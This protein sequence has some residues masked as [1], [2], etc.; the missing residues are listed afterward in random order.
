MAVPLR[1]G[2]I[3]WVEVADANGLVKLRPAVIVT[4]SDR[5]SDA[6]SLHAVAVTS[7]VTEPLPSDHVLLPWHPKGHPRTRLNR[8]CAAV[9][10]WVVQI[11]ADDIREVAGNVPGAVLVE[12]LRLIAEYKPP[13]AG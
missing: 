12:I 9:C 1:L 4:P 13:S 7:R 10:S 6:G 5:I 3:V 2:S 11:Q 8:R